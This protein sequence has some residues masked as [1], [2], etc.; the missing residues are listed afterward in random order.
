MLRGAGHEVNW[1]DVGDPTRWAEGV[2][3]AV[4]A[5]PSKFLAGALPRWAPAPC[6]VVSVVKG[7][8]PEGFRRVSEIVCDA[9]PGCRVAALSGP[10]FAKEVEAGVPTAV[11]AA[12][13]DEGVARAVQELFHRRNFRVYRSADL[14]GVELGGAMK[15]VYAIGAG[16]CSGLGLGDN[17]LAAMVTRALAEM[18]RLGEA[19]GGRPETFMGLSGA[20]DLMLTCYGD[21][22]RN[23]RVGLALSRGD[24]L[25]EIERTLGGV[26]EGVTTARALKQL[27]ARRGLRAPLVDQVAAVLAGERAPADA[28][29]ELLARAPDEE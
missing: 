23:R 18:R 11:V 25:A 5:I 28:L 27:A 17:S 2:D 24:A 7:I 12:S 19:L 20:G 14:T 4:L 21:Q 26:A 16:L 6:P 15:N 10:S 9:W 22:S 8:E 3:L 13:S 1:S 29:E